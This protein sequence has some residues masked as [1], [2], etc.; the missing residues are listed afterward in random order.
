MNIHRKA[1]YAAVIFICVF[2]TAYGLVFSPLVGG[3]T[4]GPVPFIVGGLVTALVV[5]YYDRFM[6]RRRSP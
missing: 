3:D 2:Y 5:V 1:L 4:V 6:E